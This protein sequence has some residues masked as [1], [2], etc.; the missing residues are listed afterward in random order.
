MG[1]NQYGLAVKSSLSYLLFLHLISALFFFCIESGK[2]FNMCISL[3][4]IVVLFCL[5]GISNQFLFVFLGIIYLSDITGVFFL[6]L[7]SLL[8]NTLCLSVYKLWEGIRI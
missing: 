1:L 7:F 3:L 8:I 6:I 5:Q 2:L 4:E